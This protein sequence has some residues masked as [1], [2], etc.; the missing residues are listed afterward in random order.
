MLAWFVLGLCI[1]A[2]V[3]LVARWF[4]NADPKAVVRALR[5]TI[6]GLVGGGAV[7]LAVTGR[8]PFAVLLGLMALS[9]LRRWRGT[10]PSFSQRAAPS[11]GQSSEVETAYLK[12]VLDHD[13]G[14][15]DGAVLKGRF[16]GQS[17]GDM[18]VDDVLEL[19]SECRQVDL[20]SAALIE[21]FLDRVHGEE[22]RERD[23]SSSYAGAPGGNGPM[24]REEA[25][26]ILGLEEGAS[27]ED[28]KQAH[29]RLMLKMHP[30]QGGSTYIAAKINQ[31]K[32]LLLGA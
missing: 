20:R 26:H 17:L 2:A 31:A 29:H 14:S 1:F 28:I 6:F 18:R 19:L 15:V 5:W 27:E 11:S 16:Q 24:T 13:T 32:E 22:W 12:M 3:F 8:I 10:I 23:Q 4:V 7:F 25:F 30:D 21:T 9:F